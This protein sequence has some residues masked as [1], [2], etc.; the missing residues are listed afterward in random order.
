MQEPITIAIYTL[1]KVIVVQALHHKYL[2]EPASIILNVSIPNVWA[3]TTE[4][5][6][7]MH[8]ILEYRLTY[9]EA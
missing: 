8:F 5:L 1:G 2:K 4:P 9:R 7:V 3:K 6:D